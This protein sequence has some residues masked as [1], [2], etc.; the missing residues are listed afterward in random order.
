[1]C[2][3]T[4]IVGAHM[5]P[6]S[7]SRFHPSRAHFSPKE[8]TFTAADPSCRYR[9]PAFAYV[10]LQSELISRVIVYNAYMCLLNLAVSASTA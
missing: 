5:Y 9:C 1:M 10:D 7:D 8:L 2:F 4:T 3:S 6:Y